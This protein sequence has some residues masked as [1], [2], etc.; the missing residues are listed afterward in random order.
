ME[1]QRVFILKVYCCAQPAVPP[2]GCQQ[3]FADQRPHKVNDQPHQACIGA[4]GVRHISLT[5][6]MVVSCPAIHETS[7]TKWM[8]SLVP[9][10]T[11]SF[12]QSGN[13][14]AGESEHMLGVCICPVS[15]MSQWLTVSKWWTIPRLNR[16]ELEMQRSELLWSLS[17]THTLFFL[18]CHVIA[19]YSNCLT[20]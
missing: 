14:E 6:K 16:K 10:T 19:A 7:Q 3:I 4:F 18:D 13:E 2:D 12:S 1:D 8:C 15:T 5:C 17:G 20:Q 9:R 11:P